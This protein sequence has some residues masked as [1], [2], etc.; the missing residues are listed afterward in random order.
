[1]HWNGNGREKRRL[2]LSKICHPQSQRI[3]CIFVTVVGM[4]CPCEKDDVVF[5]NG[6]GNDNICACNKYEPSVQPE[7]RWIPCS[8]KLPNYM[9]PVLTWDG[10]SYCVEK[11]IRYIRDEEGN[12]IEGDWWVS[13]EYND[14]ESDYYPGLRD[15]AAIAWM[16][17]P[18]LYKE[19][20]KK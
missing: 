18:E 16:S 14:I 19:E 17:L 6:K 5:G 12:P 4:E 10:V 20:K 7:Q 13:D 8:K 2:M 11:R 9:E 15:G 1:M 3:K